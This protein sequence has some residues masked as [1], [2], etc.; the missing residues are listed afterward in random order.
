MPSIS[1]YVST[2]LGCVKMRR[3]SPLITSAQS[4]V[5]HHSSLSEIICTANGVEEW[6]KCVDSS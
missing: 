1:Q 2:P 5:V 3:S 4:L 6:K